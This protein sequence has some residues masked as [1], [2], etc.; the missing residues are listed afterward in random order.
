MVYKKQMWVVL[1]ISLLLLYSCNNTTDPQDDNSTNDYS[2]ILEQKRDSLFQEYTLF[3]SRKSHPTLIDLSLDSLEISYSNVL[4]IINNNC[5]ACHS[6]SGNAPFSLLSY[7]DLVK[8]KG[9]IQEVLSRKIMPPWMADKS[10]K[11]FFN[12]P[13]ISDEERALIYNWLEMGAPIDKKEVLSYPEHSSLKLDLPDLIIQPTKKHIITTNDD[14]YE[15]I[16]YDPKLKEDIFVSGID[17][18]S[19]NPEVI[20]HLMLYLDVNNIL[21]DDGSWDCKNDGLVNKLIPIQSWSKGMRPF[22]LA[23]GLGYR[24]PKG[25]KFLLQAHYGDENNKGREVSTTLKLHYADSLKEEVAFEVI[26][27]FDIKYPKDSIMMETLSYKVEDTI[28]VLGLLPHTHFLTKKIEIF[29]VNEDTKEIIKLL[30]IPDWDYLWQGQYINTLPVIIPKGSTIYCNVVIDNTADNPTQ[31]N[32]PVRD[33]FYNTNS[34]D[35]M[36]VLVLLTKPY[37]EG[38]SQLQVAKFLK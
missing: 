10:Y 17:F 20:H 32:S 3:K 18:K 6:P 35:E 37:K 25:A 15:C 2:R 7:T 14:S 27:K 33:V 19:D 13:A 36:L 5:V 11:I 28:S 23:S 9:V 4:K 16:V 21:E 24:V 12:E 1:I 31:P 8:R 29:A 38:D 30:K 34:S 26:N 22:E